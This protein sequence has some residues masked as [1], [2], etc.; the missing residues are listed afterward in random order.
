MSKDHDDLLDQLRK[1]TDLG[2]V[3]RNAAFLRQVSLALCYPGASSPEA[4]SK[5]SETF[6]MSNLVS[7]Y[8]FAGNE[9]IPVEKLREIRARAVMDRVDSDSESELLLIHDGSLLDYSKHESKKDKRA[10]GNHNGT[11]YEYVI[12]L[13]IDPERETILGVIHDTLVSRD[14]PDDQ[15]VMDYDYEPSFSGFDDEEKERLKRNHRHQM[16]VHLHGLSGCVA[17]HDVIHVADRE[18]DD[19]FV[20]DSIMQLGRDFTIRSS[21]DRNVQAPYYDWVPEDALSMKRTGHP[22]PRG[23]VYVSLA[24]LA[25]SVPLFPYKSLPLDARGRVTD[26]RSAKRTAVLSIGTF[27]VRFY[28]KAM[29]NNQDIPIPR[30]V[31]ANVVVIRETDPPPGMAPL[32]WVLL[33]SLPVDTIEQAAWVGR[34]YELRWKVEDFFRLLKSGFNIEK[35]RL[36]N[37]GKIARLLV[38]LTL[39]ATAILNLKQSV[40]LPSTGYLN[41]GE[42]KLV[43]R[44]ALEPENDDID[45]EVRIFGF[46]AKSGGWLGRRR[47]PIGPTVLMRGVLYLFSLLDAFVRYETFLREVLENPDLLKRMFS[48]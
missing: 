9:G 21:G 36:D 14:G 19:L 28:K 39:A 37:A 3:K 4:A 20:M 16:A 27:K 2:H 40:G 15:N 7:T 5:R 24:R 1:Q 35:S 38:V 6:G 32:F 34:T 29:R 43:K 44:A 45:L 25:E 8:R 42:Y 18:F 22:I 11:G 41:D 13:A 47:D 23:Y 46:I 30:A 26:E 10:I 33:T 48:S 31:E 12:C 17:N